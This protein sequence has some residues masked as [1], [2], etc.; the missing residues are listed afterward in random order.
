MFVSDRMSCIVLKF[1]W[2]DVIIL[3]E[4]GVDWGKSDDSKDGFYY[5]LEFLL[6][7]FPK[8]HM[9]ILVGGLMQNGQGKNFHANSRS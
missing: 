8:Y 9:K 3:N 4:H 1:C 6:D 2:R 5:E 7:H